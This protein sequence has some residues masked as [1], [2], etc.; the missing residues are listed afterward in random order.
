MATFTHS[1]DTTLDE[2]FPVGQA[3]VQSCDWILISGR[4]HLM[5]GGGL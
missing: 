5:V 3:Y 4:A 2:S 1:P